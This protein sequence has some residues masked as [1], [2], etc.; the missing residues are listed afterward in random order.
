MLRE[1]ERAG[2][3][4][5][6]AERFLLIFCLFSFFF[7]FFERRQARKICKTRTNCVCGFIF[8]FGFVRLCVG[9]IYYVSNYAA[10]IHNSHN[11][12]SF[13]SPFPFPLPRSRIFPFPAPSYAPKLE[14]ENS[15][16][17]KPLCTQHP[18]GKA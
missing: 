7:F 1:G 2:E 8:L 17:C 9:H 4:E 14:D 16:K 5:R 6:K 11:P 3:R 12:L 13:R 18:L 15:S 10:E